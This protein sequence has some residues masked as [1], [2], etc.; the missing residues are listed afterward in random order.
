MAEKLLSSRENAVIYLAA[1][2]KQQ[3][4]IAEAIG[5]SHSTI[6]NILSKERVQ[7]EIK[8]VQLKLFGKDNKAFAAQF[9]EM[10]PQAIQTIQDV[11]DNP[12]SK[13]QLRFTAAQE[14]LDRSIGKPK[15]TIEMEH[16]LVKDLYDRLDATKPQ[17]L[18][19][20]VDVTPDPQIQG[21]DAPELPAAPVDK[22]D[23]WIKNLNLN[24]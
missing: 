2:G 24:S 17:D 15:Q 18:G 4:D 16:S 5:C 23:A 12:N 6:A 3:Q 11:M 8:R 14:I 7:F 13:P 9:K 19:I 20:V 1:Q 21:T 10:V 22:V